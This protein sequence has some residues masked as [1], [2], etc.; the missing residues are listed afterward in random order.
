MRFI[1]FYQREALKV[2]AITILV[3]VGGCGPTAKS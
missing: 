3:D 1:A 2:V